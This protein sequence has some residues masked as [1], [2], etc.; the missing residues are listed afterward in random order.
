MN[1]IS[2][3]REQTVIASLADQYLEIARNLPYAKIGTVNG[4]PPGSL[5][6]QPNAASITLGGQ[7]FQIYYVVNYIDDPADGTFPADPAPNDYKQVKLYVNDTTSGI[8][9]SFLTNISPEGLE[10]MASGGALSIKVF[11]SVGQPISGATVNI[12]N[13]G[14]SPAI[15]L[16]RLTDSSGNWVEV[17]LPDSYSGYHITVT[18]SGYSTDKTYPVTVQNPNPTKP[19]AT[20]SNGQV[21]PVGF[22][23]DSLSNLSF[24]TMDQLCSSLSGVGIEVKGSKIIGTP[25]ILKFDNTYTSDARGNISI[26]NIEWDT[27]AATTTAFSPYMVYGSSPAQPYLVMPNSNQSFNLILGPETPNSLL[28]LATDS[29]TG[30]PIQ[31][32]SVDLQ[33]ISPASDKIK[34]TGGSTFSQQDWSGGSG[35]TNFG[36]YTRYFQD[37]G[38]VNY[39]SATSG[40]QLIKNGSSYVSS[41]SLISSSFDSGSITTSYTNLL[42]Q[43]TSQNHSTF[44][45][46]QIATNNDNATWHFLGPDGTTNTYYTIPG[47]AISTTNNTGRYIRYK[48][49]LST[50]DGSE[51]PA[52]SSITINY[53]SGCSTPG[54]V[55]FTALQSGTGNYSLN[56]S[57]SGYQSQ[58]IGGINITGNNILKVS[59]SH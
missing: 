52:L 55:I 11:D 4:N 23:I 7:T 33:T 28:V 59:L 56:V 6:D 35:Q 1:A 15:N 58:A 17:G 25:N 39:N 5:P 27:Y 53:I 9:N 10:N 51:T 8:S 30:N 13:N 26:S 54:Q 48:A 22:S 46:F 21:T 41:G 49:L 31:G 20:I 3:Y 29:S 18:K 40:L 47:T 43:P 12:V 57:A 24:L 36:D 38:N 45:K 44:V 19:D 14:I 37:D 2:R 42:W 16:T 50:S 32:A 34:L